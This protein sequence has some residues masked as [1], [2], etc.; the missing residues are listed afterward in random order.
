M[1]GQEM[2]NESFE[3]FERNRKQL[4]AKYKDKIIAVYVDRVLG[5]YDSKSQAYAKVPS[6]HN[7]DPGTF[8]IKDC[9]EKANKG[10][11]VYQSRVSF[12]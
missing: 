10:I 12:D 9:S 3:Y 2:F 7:I 4:T 5:E 11:R 8:V 6:Q 1:S